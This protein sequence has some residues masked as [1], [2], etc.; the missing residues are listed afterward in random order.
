MGNILATWHKSIEEI[1]K[2]YWKDLQD[3]DSH[4]FFEWD[5]LYSLEHSGSI[6]P[7]LGW[8]PIH[9]GIWKDNKPIALAPLY[10]KNHSYG[11]FIFDHSFVKLSEELGLRYYPKL[12]GMS[13]LSPV[14][15]YKF[16]IS[17]EENAEEITIRMLEI[18][19]TFAIRN[20]ILSC[21][22]LYVD[23]KWKKIAEKSKYLPWLN[24]QSIWQSQGE[25]N[26]DEY[27]DKFNSNQRRNIKRERKSVQK[28]GLVISTI[29]S[30]EIDQ[31]ILNTMYHLYK[32]HCAKWGVWGSK[33]LTKEFFTSLELESQ[34]DKLLFFSAHH[35][36]KKEPVAMSLC[37]KNKNMLWG[38]YW[39]SKEEIDCLHFEVCYYS[40][41]TWA[42]K[43]G[44]KSFDPGAG[45]SHKSRRGFVATPRTSL[46]KW[47][48]RDMNQLIKE[49]L[50]KI[51]SYINEE[52][53]T[54]NNEVPFKSNAPEL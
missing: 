48:Q 34:R 53:N 15:G 7:K 5:W 52:I 47:Y 19:D 21:N 3:K 43:H 51:N 40:P 6:S 42:I 23:P 4:P 27:L 1:P 35:G 32:Q 28:S 9:L 29:S 44:I 13:P 26:F 16:F 33:Y 49:W 54:S 8:Q 38:R 17:P 2:E 11:E 39:G 24:R 37:I 45:G 46:H 10:L 41:I 30:N 31:S 36:N 25:K 50:P 14:E 12:I 18:I 20:G 22:F